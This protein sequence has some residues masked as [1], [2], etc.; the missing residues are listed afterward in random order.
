M[1]STHYQDAVKSS[2]NAENIIDV[3]SQGT[4]QQKTETPKSLGAGVCHFREQK[5]AF[6]NGDYSLHSLWVHSEQR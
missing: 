3:E 5:E 6:T 2:K 1:A 4:T